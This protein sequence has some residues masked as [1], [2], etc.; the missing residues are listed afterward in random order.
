[1]IFQVEPNITKKDI[2]AVTKYM[3][4]G[5]WIT[6]HKYTRK[7]ENDIANFVG[8]KYSVSVPNG[9]TAIYLSLLSL[10]I[11]KGDKVAVPN[12]TMI[13]TINAVIWAGAEPVLVDVDENFCMSLEKLKKVKN[14]KALIFV[15]LNGRVGEGEAIG[16]WCKK[17]NVRLIEDSAHSLGTVYEKCSAGNLGD[18]SIFS[19]TPHKIITTGQGGMI[20]TNSKKFFNFLNDFK[21]FNRSGGKSDWHSGFGLN[22]KFTDLQASLGNSQFLRIKENIKT[23]VKIYKS[24]K[25]KVS[26]EYFYINDFKEN[27]TP[28]FFDVVCSNSQVRQKL[29]DYLLK[30]NI[31]TRFSYPA[32][33]KQKFLKDL[34]NGNLE[35]SE[36]IHNRILWLPSSLNLNNTDLNKIIEKLNSFKI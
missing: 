32:L 24:Y 33:S 19:F 23:K 14:L 9:T 2:N 31:E 5:G 1:M 17:N 28:W 18:L 11:K 16:N 36:K 8:R 13:G 25:T 6:E 3:E 7:F 30:N 12:I 22:F 21:T 35:F 4:S 26:N 20:L 27:E 29:Y 10:G 15:P 34:D